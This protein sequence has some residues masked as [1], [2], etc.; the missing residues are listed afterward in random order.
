[1]PNRSNDART[2][3]EERVENPIIYVCQRQDKS[4]NQLDGKLTGML[5]L[6]DMVALD[7]RDDPIAHFQPETSKDRVQNAV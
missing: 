3:S 5:S 6:L 7:V 1:M 4:L 2:S